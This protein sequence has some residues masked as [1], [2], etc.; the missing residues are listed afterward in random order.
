M[1]SRATCHGHQEGVGPWSPVSCSPSS[2]PSG[3]VFHQEPSYSLLHSPTMVSSLSRLSLAFLSTRCL[4]G[5]PLAPLLYLWACWPLTESQ[6]HCSSCL[7][8]LMGAG[9]KHLLSDPPSPKGCVCVGGCMCVCMQWML[10]CG[11][12]GM[13]TDLGPQGGKGEA[14]VGIPRNLVQCLQVHV[15]RLETYRSLPW[16]LNGQGRVSSPEH[17]LLNLV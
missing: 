14:P 4:V 5:P 11:Q 8:P 10:R 9:P 7:K 17:F 2:P 13:H 6:P 12:P 15:R 16:L 3:D 1:R